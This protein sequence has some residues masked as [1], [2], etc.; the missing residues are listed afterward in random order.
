MNIL[1]I[2]SGAREQ[3]LI[4]ACAQSKRPV[5]L[6][7][8]GSARNPAI[9]VMSSDY[10]VGSL[11]DNQAICRQARLWQIDY[12]II[13]PEGPL[14][15]GL[16]DDLSAMGIH[17]IGPGREL[18]QIETSKGF[19]RTLMDEFGIAGLPRYRRFSAVTGLEAYLQALGE[20]GYVIKADGLMGGKGV[21]V[22]GVHLFSIAEGLRYAEEIF[23]A[24]QSVVVEEKLI[25]QEF[26]LLCFADG[27]TL[28]P[29]PAV[30]DHKRAFEGDTGPN[31]G[32]MGT[33]TDADHLL[34]FLNASDYQQAVVICEQV[35][36]ALQQRCGKPYHGIL[37][38]GFM[39]TASGVYV[40]EFNARFGD[41]EALNLLSL[42]K[43]DF[44]EIMEAMSKGQLA[45]CQIEFKRQ[46]SVCKYAVPLGYPDKPQ[47]DLPID[48]QAVPHSER[49]FLGAVDWRDGQLVATGSRTAAYVG[50]GQTLA[51]AE[52]EAEQ[53]ISAVKG[54]LFHRRDIGKAILIQQRVNMMHR[55]R[56]GIPC[57]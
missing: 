43:T 19:A 50:L 51:D 13:G 14:A 48:I 21:K 30:Q 33:Y 11:L 47:C 52:Q 39:V 56:E 55:L 9:Q 49:L 40:I 29:M 23:A 41:P 2:G 24:G 35:L 45:Q 53:G 25:G 38:G 3:A 5:S 4:A 20:S 18:A 16:A 26:S 31:T 15:Q 12:A 8:F 36:Q 42:L 44:V 54:A 32:G 37:Y 22:A 57:D 7:C 1:V 46:A 34:P 28:C 6:F 10:Q 27:Q 17:V